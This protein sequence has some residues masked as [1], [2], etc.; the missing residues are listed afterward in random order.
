MS[1][2]TLAIYCDI[3]SIGSNDGNGNKSGYGCCLQDISQDG[4]GYCVTVN[5][6]RDDIDSKYLTQ[7]NFETVLADPYDLS[8]I[9][10]PTE[11]YIG[12]TVFHITDNTDASEISAARP[13]KQF[14]AKKLQ[15]WPNSSWAEM[16]RF[17]KGDKAVGLIYNNDGSNADHWIDE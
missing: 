9:E 3:E 11:K 14:T 12:I 16:Y 17:E 8:S 2:Y 10:V 4:G 1:S 15:P 7:A 13:F 5:S 6:A